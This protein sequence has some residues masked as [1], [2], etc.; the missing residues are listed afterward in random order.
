MVKDEF[1]L[2]KR[3]NFSKI[4]SNLNEKK[5]KLQLQFI[6]N[7]TVYSDNFKNELSTIS[8]KL[9]SIWFNQWCT[10]RRWLW[11]I[12]RLECI[13]TSGRFTRGD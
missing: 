7:K 9:M 10:I 2:Y 8:S 5:I 13:E 3:D 11:R 12:K 1:A 6:Q 4:K